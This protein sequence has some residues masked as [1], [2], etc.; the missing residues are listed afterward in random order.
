[1]SLCLMRTIQTY[2]RPQP[3]PIFFNDWRVK[4]N[5]GRLGAGGKS[6]GAGLLEATGELD[7]VGPARH[8]YGSPALCRSP[9][10]TK[11]ANMRHISK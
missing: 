7:R 10:E 2:N 4:L 8:K 11:L 6:I 3:H 9:R 5:I 1:M